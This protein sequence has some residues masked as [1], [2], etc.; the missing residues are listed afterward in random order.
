MAVQYGQKIKISQ[1][2]SL[3]ETKFIQYKWSYRFTV[4]IIKYALFQMCNV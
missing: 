4:W 1:I 2:I 3:T